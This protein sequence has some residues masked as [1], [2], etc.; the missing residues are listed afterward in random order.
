MADQVMRMPE[1]EIQRQP[2]TPFVQRQADVEEE[3]EPG[4]AIQ[5]KTAG[6]D[7]GRAP[8][9]VAEQI[10]A[11]RGRG[12]PLSKSIRSFFEP[13]FGYNFSQVRVH[14]DSRAGESAYAFRMTCVLAAGDT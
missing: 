9:H 2:V 10:N 11:M 8:V 5:L 6:S 13:R 4:E 14:T 1:S 3:E 12:Q 7:A